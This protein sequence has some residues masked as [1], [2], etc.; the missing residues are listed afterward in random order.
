MKNGSGGVVVLNFSRL[1]Y[2]PG[3]YLTGTRMTLTD[4]FSWRTFKIAIHYFSLR[5]TES[6]WFVNSPFRI[7]PISVIIRI[8]FNTRI[9]YCIEFNKTMRIFNEALN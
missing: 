9:H 4:P 2:S 1:K 5:L 8:Y 3:R 7:L 6:V